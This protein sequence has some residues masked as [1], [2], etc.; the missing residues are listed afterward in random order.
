MLH[1][2]AWLPRRR[3]LTILVFFLCSLNFRYKWSVCHRTF[4]WK[5]KILSPKLV[6]KIL[7]LWKAQCTG[8][9]IV[10]RKSTLHRL[11]S[12]S[13]FQFE[14]QKHMPMCY[15]KHQTCFKTLGVGNCTK[16]INKTSEY[17]HL[18]TTLFVYIHIHLSYTYFYL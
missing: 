14:E 12:F 15:W 5:V 7:I 2:K 13:F 18:Q 10:Q 11:F 16:H 4:I 6:L 17:H 8:F 9:S 3:E 1:M